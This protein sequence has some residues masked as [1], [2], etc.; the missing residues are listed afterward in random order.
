M[1]HRR[2]SPAKPNHFNALMQTDCSIHRIANLR[3]KHNA[4][5]S[6]SLGRVMARSWHR[7]R[8]FIRPQ[9]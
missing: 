7:P 3:A 5:S 9:F 8:N 1:P 6:D 4:R 2:V